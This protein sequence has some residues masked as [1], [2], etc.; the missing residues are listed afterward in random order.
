M[1]QIKL[2]EKKP[3]NICFA[4]DGER[5]SFLQFLLVANQP[6]TTQATE[7]TGVLTLVATSTAL[8]SST[9]KMRIG[10][11]IEVNPKIKAVDI[12]MR[13]TRPMSRKKP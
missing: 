4:F 9:G 2:K 11:T 5:L 8:D 12:G 1:L 10:T 13:N 3:T 7:V 6:W